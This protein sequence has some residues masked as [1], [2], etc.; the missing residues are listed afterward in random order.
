MKLL[1][2]TVLLFA[3]AAPAAG[4][5]QCVCGFGDGQFT[6]ATMS[7][8]GDMSDWAPI[9]AD[10]DN[11]VCDGPSGG[12]VDRDAPV[13]STGRDL[14]HFAYTWDSS[15]I[16]LF[17]QR[18]GSGANIQ[19]FAYYAD[20]DNDGLMETGEPV[21]GVT[22]RGSNTRVEVY[23][24]TYV[25]VAAGGD[26]M[27]DGNGFGDGY[28]LPGSFANVPSQ[29]TRAGTWGSTTGQ[30]MEFWVTW[31]E[32]G[33]APNSP[34]TFH[35]ASSN[36]ALGAASFTSQVDDN[37]SGC[38]G[39]I[40]STVIASLTFAPDLAIT[41]LVGQTVVG[42]HTLT[43]T[44]NA[45]D[46][47]D[48]QS[49]IG[50]TFTPVVSYYEDTDGSGTLTPGDLLLTD[51]DGDG[52]PNTSPL[53][54]GAAVTILIAYDVA[55]GS[56]GD[57]AV[58]TTTAA[59]D[60][61]PLVTDSVTD[62]LDVAVAPSLIVTKSAAVVSDPVN[63]GVNP[64]AI[65]GSTVEYTI[66]VTNVGPGAV[67]ADSFE[68][69]D[70]IPADGCLL[71]ADL[72]GPLSGPVSFTDGSPASGLVYAFGG[73]G[74]NGD[75]LEFSNNGGASF[76]YVPTPNGSG[77]DPDVTHVRINP[78]GSFAADSGAGSPNATFTFRMLIN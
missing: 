46:S 17:T 13:Q 48:L 9:H 78:T 44:G 51:T 65:P 72:S 39:L 36:A 7:I 63:L 25:A 77:C 59:S 53:A 57:T 29:P 1:R 73:L 32:L 24:F 10:V 26:P 67:D 3:L 64:K 68:V 33:L 70:A 60:F 5:A 75:D 6:L 35:V 11:N 58:V 15:N 14:T 66:L 30:Q 61:N 62:T 76:A 31:A 18:T 23:V 4:W 50:G 19:S 16:Y 42:A 37:L 21:I 2:I 34:F 49:S 8:D 28:T 22:W 41:A 12:L 52:Q 55:G 69:L 74:D 71:L 45:T 47:F 54:A 56:G 27:G 40:G 38:G 20:V 43:N